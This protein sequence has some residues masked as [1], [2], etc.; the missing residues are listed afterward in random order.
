M[1]TIAQHAKAIF[2]EAIEKHAPDQWPSFLDAACGDDQELR[3]RVE[4]LLQ[5][6]QDK[7]SMFDRCRPPAVMSHANKWAK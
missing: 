1:S 4:G 7:D 6:H 3:Q 2:L 5:A